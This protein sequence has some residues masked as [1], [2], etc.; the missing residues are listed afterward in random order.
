[1]Q[2]LSEISTR[3]IYY[4]AAI[5]IVAIVL[6]SAL[7]TSR[8]FTI[9]TA[10]TCPQVKTL[11]VTGEGTV[12]A[13]PDEALLFLAVQ[14]Q[15]TSATQAGSEN[16]A[17]M[18]S[19]MDALVG[20]GIGKSA[21][22]TVSYSLT[23][24]HENKQD[25]TTPPRIVGY[26]VQN[27][28]QVTI[29]DFSLVG[30]AL[31]AAIGAGVNQVQGVVFTLSRTSYAS[32]EKQALQF[33]IQDADAKAKAMASSLGVSLLGPI[34]VTPGYTFQPVFEKLALSAAQTPIQPGPLQVTA[35]V[36]IA[37]QIA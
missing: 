17:T 16:A 25:Q 34:S 8:S 23:P 18:S 21:I 32:I 14:T 27:A 13:I 24:I 6:I 9:Q 5:A 10:N 31:D 2:R 37:Y 1:V 35:N 30:K 15:A 11:Q 7:A 4:L 20:V 36:Q 3:R 29:T 12:S 22:Q 19:V 33:A 26:A 28:I